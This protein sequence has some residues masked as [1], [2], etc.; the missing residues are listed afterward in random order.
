M[1]QILTIGKT[2][3]C[4]HCHKTQIFHKQPSGLYLCRDCQLPLIEA[5]Q[6]TAVTEAGYAAFCNELAHGKDTE[7]AVKAAAAARLEALRPVP[8]VDAADF[9]ENEA[10]M[11]QMGTG[12][13]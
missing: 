11:V 12:Y 13:R 3:H 5:V 2:H 1:K 8:K 9:T 6:I 10:Y 4:G 7:T